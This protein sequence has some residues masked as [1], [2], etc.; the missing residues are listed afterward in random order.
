MTNQ[1]IN[2]ANI[3]PYRADGTL[4]MILDVQIHLQMNDKRYFHP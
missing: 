4:V 1:D 3:H 2:W